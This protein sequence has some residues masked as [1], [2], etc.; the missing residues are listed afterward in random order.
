MALLSQDE[1]DELVKF[2]QADRYLS[3]DVVKEAHRL[4]I[5]HSLKHK[6]L[7]RFKGNQNNLQFFE[8]VQ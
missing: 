1:K 8:I 3:C 6:G 4:S 7:V 2:S 5:W